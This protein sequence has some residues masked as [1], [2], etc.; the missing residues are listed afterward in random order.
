VRALSKPQTS[1]TAATG[2]LSLNATRRRSRWLANAYALVLTAGLPLLVPCLSC[3]T[4]T[5]STASTATPRS[6]CRSGV[7]W[8]IS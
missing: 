1:S 2:A 4:L 8:W 6:S 3:P 7:G 5:C